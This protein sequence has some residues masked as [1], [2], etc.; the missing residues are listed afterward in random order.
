MS[1]PNLASNFDRLG[2]TQE[3]FVLQ[4]TSPAFFSVSMTTDKYGFKKLLAI[5]CPVLRSGK[6]GM[7]GAANL[8]DTA[9]K[10]LRIRTKEQCIYLVAIERRR[11]CEFEREANSSSNWPRRFRRVGIAE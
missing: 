10:A 2:S 9:A 6:S 5:C 7:W 3:H 11:L 4:S 8:I 1:E